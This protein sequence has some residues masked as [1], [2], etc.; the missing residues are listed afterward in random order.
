MFNSD[1]IDS[2]SDDDIIWFKNN[3]EV[4]EASPQQ[5]RKRENII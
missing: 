3:K 2:N 5:N 1:S 4:K